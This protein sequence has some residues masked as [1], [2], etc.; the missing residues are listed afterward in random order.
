MNKLRKMK[1][2]I[3]LIA[4]VFATT[5]STS[6][7]NDDDGSEPSI[8]GTWFIESGASEHFI[9]GT[10]QGIENDVVDANNYWELTFKTDGTF[11]D[12]YVEDGMSEEN[13][14]TYTVDGN[15]ISLIYSGEPEPF[16]DDSYSLNSNELTY[17]N[18]EESMSGT[19]NIKYVHMVTFKKQ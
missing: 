4:V 5:L 16:P 6:C 15:T 9:N 3:L 8:V 17:S 2:V 12:I 1:T 14:G 7:K 10:S 11:T 13:T 18:V 19:D